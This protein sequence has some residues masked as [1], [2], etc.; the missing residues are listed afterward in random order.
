MP[1]ISLADDKVKNA[2]FIRCQ[3]YMGQGIQ[4]LIGYLSIT[5]FKLRVRDSAP[6]YIDYGISVC[7]TEIRIGGLYA[8][9]V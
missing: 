9:K 2:A 3:I 4:Y 1:S 7:Y 8:T 6:P 5:I